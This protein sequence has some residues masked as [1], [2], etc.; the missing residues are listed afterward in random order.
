MSLVDLAQCI[1]KVI[2][3]IKHETKKMNNTTVSCQTIANRLDMLLPAVNRLAEVEGSEGEAVKLVSNS[4]LL[5]E[6]KEVVDKIHLK[7]VK[8]NNRSVGKR[9]LLRNKDRDDFQ[10]LEVKLEKLV[11]DLHFDVSVSAEAQRRD[12]MKEMKSLIEKMADEIRATREANNEFQTQFDFEDSNHPRRRTPKTGE[13]YN[14]SG[15]GSS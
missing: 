10:D 13:D 15:G 14:G 5:A 4:N 8:Y 3:I 1:I 7:V 12:D 6:T 9:F 2:F 11:K